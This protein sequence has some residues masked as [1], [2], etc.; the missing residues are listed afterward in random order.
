MLA[1][2]TCNLRLILPLREFVH[3][4]STLGSPVFCALSKECAHKAE[5][6]S[7]DDNLKCD[8]CERV[9]IVTESAKVLKMA[10]ATMMDKRKMAGPVDTTTLP[11]YVEELPLAR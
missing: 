9:S 11:R 4:F 6:P 3:N 2:W 1:K 5:A 10:T 8:Q 7:V